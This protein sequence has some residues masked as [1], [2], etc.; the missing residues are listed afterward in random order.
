MS[1]ISSILRLKVWVSSVASILS[2]MRQRHVMLGGE[3]LVPVAGG[4]F[5]A[6]H[7]NFAAVVRGKA[8]GCT[9]QRGADDRAGVVAP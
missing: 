7:H 9:G 1:F 4:S 6:L 2:N 3:D 8:D 5:H